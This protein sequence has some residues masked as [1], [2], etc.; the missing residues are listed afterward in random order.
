[1]LHPTVD[2]EESRSVD[3]FFGVKGAKAGQNDLNLLL[4]KELKAAIERNGIEL[5]TVNDLWDYDKC[6]I[7]NQEN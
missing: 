2:N 7:R 1:M 6:Q 3:N 5:I 4:S